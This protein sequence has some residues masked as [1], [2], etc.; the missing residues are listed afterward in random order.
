MDV[1]VEIRC[2]S[3]IEGRAMEVLETEEE[4]LAHKIREVIEK[5]LED[6]R[7]PSLPIKIRVDV[8]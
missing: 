5:V 6:K 8:T 7:A 4:G 2:D 1:A 3:G